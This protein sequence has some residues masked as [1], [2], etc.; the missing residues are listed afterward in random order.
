[1]CCVYLFLPQ[2][3][4]FSTHAKHYKHSISAYPAQAVWT[5]EARSAKRPRTWTALCLCALSDGMT[6]AV[7]VMRLP[8]HRHSQTHACRPREVRPAS[9]AARWRSAQWRYRVSSAS[10]ALSRGS[11]P[12]SLGPLGRRTRSSCTRCSPIPYLEDNVSQ[13]S[14][15]K[16][17]C[18]PPP[19]S[20]LPLARSNISQSC[21]RKCRNPP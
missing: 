11:W 7:S 10:W 20:H 8:S 19:P 14:V 5:D 2:S 18:V 13:G 6:T 3:C 16:P 1:M 15:N 21:V 12:R 4:L 17:S 9:A